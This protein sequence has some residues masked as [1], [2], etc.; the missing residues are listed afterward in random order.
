M[1]SKYVRCI[2]VC[3]NTINHFWLKY[4]KSNVKSININNKNWKI[5]ARSLPKSLVEMYS[6]DE[7]PQIIKD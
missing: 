4:N 3:G 6:E 1:G 7:Y 2:A 5:I